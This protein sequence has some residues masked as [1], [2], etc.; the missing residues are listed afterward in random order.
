MRGRERKTSRE[1]RDRGRIVFW[2]VTGLER[3]DREFWKYIESFDVGMSEFMDREKRLGDNKEKSIRAIYLEMSVC[4]EK[5]KKDRAKGGIITGIRKGIEEINREEV[6]DVNG[7]Q[8]RRLRI[9]GK[10]GE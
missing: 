1:I 8:E 3:K 4:G 7:I 9:G 2:N 5:E 10:H 6:I